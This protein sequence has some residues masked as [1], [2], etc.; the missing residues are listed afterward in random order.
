M[1][2]VSDGALVRIFEN[3]NNMH[4]PKIAFSPGGTVIGAAFSHDQADTG[5][6][7]F[8]DVNTGATIQ[9]DMFELWP[10][11]FAFSRLGNRYAFYSASG[12]FGVAK[13]PY[14]RPAEPYGDLRRARRFHRFDNRGEST[15]D[16]AFN[17]VLRAQRHNRRIEV[18]D[19]AR[20]PASQILE[21]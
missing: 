14:R 1:F 16:R 20:A 19:L 6:V 12:L 17:A 5:A 4:F 11:D 9:T 10:W 3:G 21:H 2:R 7:Q 18:I 13:A 8:W 15:V